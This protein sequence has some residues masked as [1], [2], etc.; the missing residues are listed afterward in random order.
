MKRLRDWIEE[1]HP[2]G[3]E[4]R[5]HFFLRFFDSDLVSTPGQWQVVAGGVFAI[6]LSL[7]LILTPAYHHKY[8]EL[9]KLASAEPLRQA[10]VADVLFVVTLAML[11]IALFTTFQWPSLFPGLRDYLA[12]GSLPVRLRDVFVAKFSALVAFAGLFTVG[13]TFLPS[14]ILPA[15]MSG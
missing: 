14:L 3:F 12:L 9:N 7:S 6:L 13:I 4:L 8:L 11:L 15:V 5:R 2:A 1:T 10:V